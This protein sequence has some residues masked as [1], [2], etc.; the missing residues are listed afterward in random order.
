METQKE[1]TPI[2]GIKT[3]LIATIHILPGFEK[4]VK[5]ALKTMEMASG[6]ETGCEQFVANTQKDA[7]QT[8]V[9]F[10]VYKSDEAFQLHKTSPHAKVFFEFVKGKIVNDKIETVFLTELSTASEAQEKKQ[11]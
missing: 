2:A 10:E 5:E 7:P 1:R 4:A 6:K 8:V 3:S 9:I 11:R